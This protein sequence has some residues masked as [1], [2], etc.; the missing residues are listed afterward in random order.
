MKAAAS[1]ETVPRLA[2][3]PRR[4]LKG[5]LSKVSAIHWSKD[6]KRLVSV[7]QD[8]KL[9]VWNAFTMHKQH[10]VALRIPWVMTCAFSPAGSHLAC[11]GLHNKCAIYSLNTKSQTPKC[12]L[13]GHEG[14]VSCV[15]FVE[16]KT[17]VTSSGDRTCKYWDVDTKSLVKTFTGHEHDV[18][19]YKELANACYTVLTWIA[20]MHQ[21]RT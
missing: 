9:I 1:I 5:H 11:G 10:M 6:S 8:G 16:N 20:W 19:R 12:E 4:V 17:L 18:M 2:L 15:R 3:K 14:Y 21:V 13:V 7:S